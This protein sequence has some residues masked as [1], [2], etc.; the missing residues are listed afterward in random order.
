M[1]LKISNH[2]IKKIIIL[3]STI[4]LLNN[5]IKFTNQ[6]AISQEII[7]KQKL[8]TTVKA[9][10]NWYLKLNPSSKV[11]AKLNSEAKIRLSAKENLKEEDAY[12]NLNKSLTLHSQLVYETPLD[13]YVRNL[14]EKY[15]FDDYLNIVFYLLHEIANP[16]SRWKP[17]LDVLPRQPESIAFNYWLRK[18]PI[19]EEL[20]NTPVLSMLI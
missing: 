4:L 12:L 15:G 8:E 18:G 7:S 5:L 10:N 9:F 1:S 11:E 13:D 3:F 17:Y 2:Q 6:K 19:E 14:E 16:A 20:L